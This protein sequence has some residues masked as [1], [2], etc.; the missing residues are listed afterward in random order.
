MFAMADKFA[1]PANDSLLML[2]YISQ[3]FFHQPQG[4]FIF[5]CDTEWIWEVFIL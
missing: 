2:K 3:E 4:A 5:L 1:D